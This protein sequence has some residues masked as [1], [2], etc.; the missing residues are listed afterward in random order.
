MIPIEELKQNIPFIVYANLK[1][2]H[3]IIENW[4]TLKHNTPKKHLFQGGLRGDKVGSESRNIDEVF[5]RKYVS[6]GN[7]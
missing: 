4:S 5:Q 3:P 1:V 7:S 2:D 6:K